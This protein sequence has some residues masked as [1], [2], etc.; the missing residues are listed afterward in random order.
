[1]QSFKIVGIKFAILIVKEN[2]T[3]TSFII[4][5]EQGQLIL[6]WANQTHRPSFEY[7]WGYRNKCTMSVRRCHILPLKIARIAVVYIRLN[8]NC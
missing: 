5:P 6:I 2:R 3:H 7:L 8:W 1:M 4:S